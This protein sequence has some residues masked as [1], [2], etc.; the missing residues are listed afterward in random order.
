M[1][2]FL[3]EGGSRNSGHALVFGCIPGLF[4]QVRMSGDQRRVSRHVLGAQS[5]EHR[6]RSQ[7]VDIHVYLARLCKF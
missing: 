7:Q 6:V 2:R 1:L 4:G 5:C 3:K